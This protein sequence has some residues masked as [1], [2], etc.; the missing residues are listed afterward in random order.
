MQP[1]REEGDGRYTE[2]RKR[3]TG[4]Q[5]RTQ[6]YICRFELGKNDDARSMWDGKKREEKKE[7]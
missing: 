7:G 6:G 4:R 5:S 1:H 3:S 2:K